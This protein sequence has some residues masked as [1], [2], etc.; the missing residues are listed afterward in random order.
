MAAQAYDFSLVSPFTSIFTNGERIVGVSASLGGAAAGTYHLARWFNLAQGGIFNLKFR[1]TGNA[2][3]RVGPNKAGLAMLLNAP[4]NTTVTTQVYVPPG[5]FRLDIEL[6]HAAGNCGLCFLMFLPDEVVY[7]SSKDGWVFEAGTVPDDNELTAADDPRLSLPVFSVLPNWRNGILERITYL[8]DVMASETAA[9]QSSSVR[10]APR[11]QFDVEFARWNVVRARLD[12]FA[13]GVGSQRFLVPLYTEQYR[14]NGGLNAGDDQ[15]VFPEDT[16]ALRE[17]MVGDLVMITNGDPDVYKVVT[18]TSIDLVA[19]TLDF[20]PPLDLDWPAGSRV[21]PIHEAFIADKTEFQAPTDRVATVKF[22]FELVKPTQRFAG[23]WGYCSPLWRFPIDWGSDVQTAHERVTYTLDNQSGPVQITDPGGRAFVGERVSVLL[24]GR[25]DLVNFRRFIAAANGRA[26]RFY[27]PSFTRNVE[28]VADLDGDEMVVRNFGFSEY[29]K[30]SYWPRTW[31]GVVQNDGSPTLYR[32][33][34]T[35]GQLDEKRE[36]LGLHSP[37]PPVPLAKIERVQFIVPSRFDQDTFELQHYVDEAKAVRVA[38]VTRSVDGD[39]MPD[40]ECW[41]TSL[42]YPVEAVEELS[43]AM[44]P[45]SGRVLFT[46]VVPEEMASGLSIDGGSLI[47]KVVTYN[48]EPEDALDTAF[49]M[50]GGTLAAPLVTESV[51]PELLDVG[52]DLT[53]GGLREVLLTQIMEPEGI[54]TSFELT[55]GT[56]T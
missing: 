46:P 10:A 11:R 21:M 25:Q 45:D 40:I 32:R 55:G 44:A 14:P 34:Q 16:L 51:E 12:S 20:S 18:V 5:K 43:P 39:G 22:R 31:I 4:A 24:Q 37:L 35:L 30:Q 27:M 41:T 3:L 9:E 17:F 52:F 15:I 19:D 36:L 26:E 54:D 53:N 48:A 2:A 33:A 42:S 23:S 1:A 50:T 7:K 38:V 49:V 13:V 8:T 6:E 56:I 29:L 28:P 47:T